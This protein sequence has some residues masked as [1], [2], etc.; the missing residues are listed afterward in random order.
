[1]EPT[2]GRPPV[3]D[4]RAR[5]LRA[6][7]L[8]GETIRAE[9]ARDREVLEWL[10]DF[11]REVDGRGLHGVEAV[12]ADGARV[13][14]RVRVD[15]KI[16]GAYDLRGDAER[17]FPNKVAYW[18]GRA[19][20]AFL[21]VR[22]LDGAFNVTASH[23]AAT[24][25][26]VKWSVRS[27]RGE[28]P[29]ALVGRSV[30]ETSPRIQRRL[31]QGLRAGGVDVR[32]LGVTATPETIHALAVHREGASRTLP[33]D[34]VRFAR[35]L[36]GSEAEA[37][38]ARLPTAS[39]TGLLGVDPPGEPGTLR[40]IEVA[41]PR[42]HDT[43][44]AALVRLGP[45]VAQAL[46]DHWVHER[47]AFDVLVRELAETRWPRSPDCAFF[48][49]L[50]RRLEI[51]PARFP[52]TPPT[53]VA[54]PFEGL[55]IGTDFANG[56]NWRKQELL[57]ELGFRV[58]PVT[59]EV[60][61]RVVDSSTP[62]GSFPLH[63]PD[64]TKPEYQRMAIELARAREIPVVLFD[65]DGDRLAVVDERGRAIHGADLACLL[66][67]DFTGPILIDVRYPRYA[68]DALSGTGRVLD[69]SI[70]RGPVGYAFYIE[71]ARRIE[72]ALRDGA[73][74]VSLFEGSGRP[75]LVSREDLGAPVAFGI[76]PSG[77]AFFRANGYANDASY[78][79]GAVLAR[80]ARARAAG[81]SLAE[82][83]DA[84]PR[85]PASPPELRVRMTPDI[86][87][88]GRRQYVRAVLDRIEIDARADRLDLSIDPMDGG[89]IELREGGQV[90]AQALVR[91]SNNESVFGLAFEGRTHAWRHRLEEFVVGRMLRTQIELDGTTVRADF[92]S[93]RTSEYLKRSTPENRENG[94]DH[95]SVL[96]R[97]GWTGD[98]LT[99]G[100]S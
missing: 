28:R 62:D 8:A 95:P 9:S 17:G 94:E 1:M 73:P 44:I 79:L 16:F 67:Q 5:E 59:G 58:H 61:G 27:R 6:R 7:I 90:V 83:Y 23:N 71:A 99:V 57:V 66:A 69:R 52:E 68:V 45:A 56:S 64:P 38:Y 15:R 36:D 20:A 65:E 3:Q 82:L 2:G 55:S 12:E 60:D 29:L 21:R 92:T 78:F 80:Y 51:D 98:A 34:A 25:D 4:P 75:L 96:E 70:L 72:A 43:W 32:D 26:G 11:E 31:M 13:Y 76:E 47:D 33:A 100:L 87:V 85:N 54:R 35:P 89:L 84:I 53:A 50:C 14:R 46:Y 18:I 39:G 24:D 91:S 74:A 81:A 48:E 30:R 63:H 93:P 22:D 49:R 86:P 42:S 37:I 88:A 77:H 40:A 41:F 97:L 10:A 19:A